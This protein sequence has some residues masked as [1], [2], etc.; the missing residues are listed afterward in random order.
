MQ[1]SRSLAAFRLL[2]ELQAPSTWPAGVSS[3][4]PLL[5]AYTM[6]SPWVFLR[7][8]MKGNAQLCFG[9]VFQPDVLVHVV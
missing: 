1:S 2:S 6:P 5:G 8:A 7:E 3:V 9:L 4:E